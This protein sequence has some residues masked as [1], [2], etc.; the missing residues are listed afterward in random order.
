MNSVV[1]VVVVLVVAAGKAL[2]RG[3]LAFLERDHD[4]VTLGREDVPPVATCRD[5]HEGDDRQGESDADEHADDEGDHGSRV[6]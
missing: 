5:R 2:A 4:L 3:L 6:S 1:A